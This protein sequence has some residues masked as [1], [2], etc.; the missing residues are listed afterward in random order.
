MMSTAG[1]G[2]ASDV[3]RR[4]RRKATTAGRPIGRVVAALVVVISVAVGIVTYGSPAV[5]AAP[6]SFVQVRAQEITSGRTNTLAFSSGNTAGNLIVVGVLWS[7]SGNVTVTDSQGNA[8]AAAGPRTAWGSGSNFS[9]QVFYAKNVRGG[10]NAVTATFAS[11]INRFGIVYIHEYAGLDTANPLDVTRTDVGTSS[12]MAGGSVNT[13]A[14]GDLL[15]TFA[16]S[17]DAVTST[18]AGWSTRSTAFDNRTFDRIAGAAGPYSATATHNGNRWVM[19]L[20]AFRAASQGPVDTQPPTVPSGLSANAFSTTQVNLSWVV[21]SDN[22]GVTGYRVF[23]NGTPIA[24]PSTTTY[25][26][27]G[28]SPATTYTYA[29]SAFDAAGNESSPSTGVPVTTQSPPLDT[30]PPT[31][32][33][34]APADQ[35]TV[36]GTVTVGATAGDDVGVVG[37]QF[38]LDG[39]A[40]AAE[41][42]A[43]P[44]SVSWDTR[45]AVNGA[46]MLSARARDAAG[47]NATST[48]R[49]VT[50]NNTTAPPSAIVA[51]YAFD[52]SGTTALDSSGNGLSG[53]LF[54]GATRAAGK[55]GTAISL[56]GPDD[57]VGPF[58]ST[59]HRS[60]RNGARA[61][62][63][64]T[65]R[66]TQDRE[67][68]GSSLR[69]APDRTCSGTAQARCRPAT[70]ITSPASTTPPPGRWTCISTASSTTA[71]C[72]APSPGR[73]S[74]LRTMS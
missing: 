34:T 52:E 58:R 59:T 28:L 3:A 70:G 72:S 9:E 51:G 57:Y 1:G 43:S 69:R 32:A 11:S 5:Q 48:T 67:R 61:G 24:T 74:T 21:S 49:T 64:S 35:S 30:S 18:G 39:I 6:P 26:D 65:R 54:N 50:V 16:G 38:L 15:F 73:S 7:N 56:E 68:S 8:Y 10:A 29:V 37:V 55:Y 60:C 47:N 44:Y 4:N 23:R 46:H 25:Q 33:L 41:D 27:T 53:T 12:A 20:V 17:S 31:V 62:S 22:V 42:T 66:S 40:L 63:N 19:Q 13:T 71:C 2:V 14:A 36:S 45:T